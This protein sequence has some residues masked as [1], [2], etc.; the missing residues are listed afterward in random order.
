[1]QSESPESEG[2][3]D[4][5]QIEQAEFQLGAKRASVAIRI[6]AV[7]QEIVLDGDGWC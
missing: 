2:G 6:Y 1:M 7:G 5:D 4:P 3:R